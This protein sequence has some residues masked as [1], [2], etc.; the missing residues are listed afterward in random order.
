MYTE[1]RKEIKRALLGKTYLLDDGRLAVMTENDFRIPLGVNDGAGSVMLFGIGCRSV[2]IETEA[3]P[4]DAVSAARRAMR[5]VGR[6]LVLFEQPDAAACMRRYRLT[7]P[8]VLTF[9]YTEEG[10]PI[11][12][13]WTGRGPLSF[14]S[15]RL[16]MRAFFKHAPEGMKAVKKQKS[17]SET[18]ADSQTISSN[19]EEEENGSQN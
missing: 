11:L 4:E 1:V 18:E 12:A 14:I 6:E 5:Y 3:A 17:A 7:R 15:R 2:Y 10:V 16:V 13:A 9:R 8:V 19:I